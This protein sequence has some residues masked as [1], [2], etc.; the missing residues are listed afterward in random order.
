VQ[1]AVAR[2]EGTDLLDKELDAM[3]NM[4]CQGNRNADI[5][6]DTAATQVSKGSPLTNISILSLDHLVQQDGSQVDEGS[7]ALPLQSA[8]SSELTTDNIS[9]RRCSFSG[10]SIPSHLPFSQI[11]GYQVPFVKCSPAWPI[12][13]AMDVFKKVPQQPHFHPLRQFMHGLREGMA[14]GLM[15]SFANSVEAISKS[16]MADSIASFDEKIATLRLLKENGFNVEFLQRSLIRLLKIKHDHISYLTEKD[17]LKA[18]LLEKT[19]SLSQIDEQ[20]DKK[21]QT[22][23]KLEEELERARCEAQKIAKEKECGDEELSR[24]NA[25]NSS[26][27]E[28]CAGAELQFQSIL[29]E[30]RH[31]SLT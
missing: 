9:L 29:A 19:T 8:E 23:A 14:L 16:S 31:K 5:C 6:T 21:K 28:A 15:V 3:I 4:V 20:L 22:I 18:Q 27:D 25:A 24:L 17:Q 1:S 26:I 7:I 11:S 12:I 10:S 2:K 30:L 13:N